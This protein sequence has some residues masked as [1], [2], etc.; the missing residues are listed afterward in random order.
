MGL[1]KPISP[2]MAHGVGQAIGV[3]VASTAVDCIATAK[4]FVVV[5]AGVATRSTRSAFGTNA[6]GAVI[7]ERAA[8]GSADGLGLVN[9]KAS[10]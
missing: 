3:V 4:V 10:V 6:L 7:A 2:S 1:A 8:V 9:A 5:L